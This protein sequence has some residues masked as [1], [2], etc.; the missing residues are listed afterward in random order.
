LVSARD[1]M[2]FEVTPIYFRLARY[3]DPASAG[4]AKS[5]TPAAAAS[6]PQ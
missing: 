5:G 6:T 2:P 1:K 3:T 4:V